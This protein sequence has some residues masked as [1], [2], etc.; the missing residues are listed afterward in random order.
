MRSVSAVCLLLM[1]LTGCRKYDKLMPLKQAAYVRVFNN[2]A[3]RPTVVNNG[4]LNTFLTFLID[5]NFDTAHS[6]IHALV[7]G[8]Y[9]LTRQL[10]NI[11][12]PTNA[13]NTVA[14]SG[15]VNYEYPGR[16]HVLTAPHMNGFDLSS[17]AQI[18]SGRHHILF[19]SRPSGDVPFDSLTSVQRSHVLVDTTLDFQP[20]EVYTIEAVVR[21]ADANVYGAYVRQESFIHEKY[22]PDSLYTEFF[23]LNSN[24]N[25]AG[26]NSYSP[27]YRWLRDSVM[28]T[29]IYNIYR[30]P[31]RS[32]VTLEPYDYMMIP[33]Y[34]KFS[35]K[36][37]Y[38]V[39]PALPD[40]NFFDPQ[41]NIGQYKVS[42]PYLELY[43]APLY[44]PNYPTNL[45]VT[46]N[47][48]PVNFNLTYPNIGDFPGVLPNLNMIQ[49]VGTKSSVYPSLNIVEV[50]NDRLYLTQIQKGFDHIDNN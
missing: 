11:S 50:V 24:V 20:G 34:D 5:P 2:I 46:F 35:T 36:G 10:F 22:S 28:L 37:Q 9:L 33:L 26:V 38:L 49:T 29:V 7:T 23:N 31:F 32:F 42:L 13:A 43:V 25:A 15:T 12:Y 17:W 4:L 19:I 30:Y 14:G 48:T 27:Y 16:E 8:D 40:S 45:H 3:T 44:N 21:D 39:L 1:F 18:P 47:E 6:P 41:G